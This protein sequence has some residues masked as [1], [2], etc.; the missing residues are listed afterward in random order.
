MA[1]IALGMTQERIIL[2][3]LMT[4]AVSLLVA[5]LALRRLF[6]SLAAVLAAGFFAASYGVFVREGGDL[7]RALHAVMFW[8]LLYVTALERDAPLARPLGLKLSLAVLFVLIASSDWAFFV[9][10]LVFY[11]L[12]HNYE[13][14]GI[15]L[16]HILPWV[17]LPVA[18]TFLAYF[19]VIIA[20]T[21]F[22]FFTVHMLLTYF[23]RMGNVLSGP[24]LGQVRVSEKFRAL[25]QAK[26]IVMWD[27]N[28]VP[29]GLH[30]AAAAYW[31]A[32]RGGSPL[33]AG[34]VAAAFVAASAVCLLRIPADRFVRGAVLA[35][36][37]AVCLDVLP[38]GWLIIPMACLIAGLPQLGRLRAELA[39][40]ERRAPRG[41]L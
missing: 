41:A 6:T 1:G 29:A 30:E 26:H 11:L 16:R 35:L 33:V 34:L 8:V 28:A 24:L 10:C 37:A 12:W 20:Y 3:T 18:L 40:E 13:N 25:Y 7:L 2:A 14:R 31:R 39:A 15:V 27:A 4:S 5:F 9:F 32:M 17:I 36:F 19:S 21:G 23:G 22:H 38:L